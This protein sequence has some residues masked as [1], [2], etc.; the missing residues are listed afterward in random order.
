MTDD[1][2]EAPWADALWNFA[3]KFYGSP[4]VQ[5]ACLALQDEGGADVPLVIFLVFAAMHG[6]S[7]DVEDLRRIEDAIGPWRRDVVQTLRHARRALRTAPGADAQR[8]REKVKAAELEAERQELVTLAGFMPEAAAETPDVARCAR[9]SLTAYAAL[10]PSI[11]G[12]PLTDFLE[13]VARFA[14]PD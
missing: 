14:R 6:R 10:A 13:L 8:L 12:A 5:Q 11:E 9:A 7:L 4:G 2:I 3:L 1:G